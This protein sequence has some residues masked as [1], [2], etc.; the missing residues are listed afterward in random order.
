MPCLKRRDDRD[1]GA[2][3]YAKD[4]KSPRAGTGGPT[5]GSFE[6]LDG[7]RKAG[8]RLST[9]KDFRRNLLLCIIFV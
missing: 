7:S 2:W 8:R 5:E 4:P 9:E 1:L 3:R 6:I